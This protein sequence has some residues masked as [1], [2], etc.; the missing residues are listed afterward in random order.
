MRDYGIDP[1][2]FS[3][4]SD[5]QLDEVVGELALR[6]P[7]CGIGSIQS[8]LKAN[9][10]VMQRERVRLS[11]HHVD[12]TGMET[13]LRTRL[14]RRQYL[15]SSPN[16]LWH[17]DGYHKLIRWRMVVHGGIDGYS[18]IPVY[19]RVAT[20]DTVLERFTHAVS[21]YGLPSRVRAD[22]GGE[23]VQV[24]HLMFEHPQRGPGRGSF[25]QGEVCIIS[26]SSAFGEIYFLAALTSSTTSFILWKMLA[27]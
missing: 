20:A 24:A 9:G 6:L 11:L 23:N 7:A 10:I 16:A 19:L 5:S 14:N 17:I 13:R 15:V 18:R 2:R 27:S 21:K 8:M 12:P 22:H 26:I 3:D 1:N 25:I 4:I